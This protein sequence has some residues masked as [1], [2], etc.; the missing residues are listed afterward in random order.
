[1][2]SLQVNNKT[3][4][5]RSVLQVPPLFTSNSGLNGSFVG[6]YVSAVNLYWFYS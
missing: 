4:N 5:H 3:L 1:M 6:N 2:F